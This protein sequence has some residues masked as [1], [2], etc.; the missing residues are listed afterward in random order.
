MTGTTRRREYNASIYVDGE[1][2]LTVDGLAC[3]ELARRF[4][5]PLFVISERQIRANVAAFR[6]AFTSRYPKT[7][8]LFAT[9]ANN[10]PAV[11]RIFTSE[12][13]GGDAFGYG[14]LLVTLLAGTDP[15]IVVLNGWN[16]QEPELELAI[17]AGAVVHLDAP[18]ELER[19]VAVA[20]RL[21]RRARIG[22]RTRLLLHSLDGVMSDWPDAGG[23]P[24]GESIGKN[25]RERDKFGISLGDLVPLCKEAMA[26]SSVELLGLHHH[27]GRELPDASLFRRTIEEQLDVGAMLRDECGWTASYYDFGGGMAF[28]RAEG[29]GP[30]GRDRGSPTY[31]EY[32]E[33]ITSSLAEGLHSRGLGRPRLLV[34]PG[35]SI[36]SDIGLL[37]GTVGMRKEVPET[38]QVWI[39]VDASQT[40][41]AN[42]G[43][44]AWYY[45]PVA[46]EDRGAGTEVVN[47]A[48]P[49]CW[50]GNLAFAVEMPRLEAGDLLAFLDTG[51][52]CDTKSQNFNL[53]CKPAT[54]LVN[55]GAAE[56]IAER[57]SLEDVVRR[58]R[59]P[60][61]LEQP[62]ASQVV[63]GWSIDAS[64]R[65]LRSH[66]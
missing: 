4:G 15:R 31:D 38:G 26:E 48:D 53:S 20:R 35:R 27:L 2:A 14:E 36:G 49:Q 37:L 17:G 43:T 10:N 16:K 41:M 46:V 39:A 5:T 52:Y 28:G 55:D 8:V 32:A 44:G 51:A 3:T 54:V 50:Y 65:V 19:V 61:R 33:V 58:F 11:R 30:L 13:A 7:D 59:L 9:K 64:S 25:M 18:E 21:R 42:I 34:E 6:D 23:D 24:E 66:G 60:P 12:G 40:Q 29:H 47:V 1:G 56:V 63:P 22:L 57:E 45:H 62:G